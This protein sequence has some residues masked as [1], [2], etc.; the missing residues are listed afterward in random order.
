MMLY[1]MLCLFLVSS[2]LFPT[3]ASEQE[4]NDSISQESRADLYE[5]RSKLRHQPEFVP[6]EWASDVVRELIQR[7]SKNDLQAQEK[8]IEGNYWGFIDKFYANSPWGEW[9]YSSF[10]ESRFDPL[11]WEDIEERSLEDDRYA[12]AVIDAYAWHVRWAPGSKTFPQSFPTLYERIIEDAKRGMPSAEFNFGAMY[13][14]F[15]SFPQFLGLQTPKIE[16]RQQAYI[17]LK[18][19]AIQGHSLTYSLLGLLV[20]DGYLNEQGKGNEVEA[21]RWYLPSRNN[22]ISQVAIKNI[23]SLYV[24]P[25]SQEGNFQEEIEAIQRKIESLQGEHYAQLGLNKAE[26]TLTLREHQFAIPKLGDLYEAITYIEEEAQKVLLSLRKITP[27]FM[28]SG[29]K[30]RRGTVID[31]STEG[32]IRKISLQTQ[33]FYVFTHKVGS[34]NYFTFGENNASIANQFIIYVNEIEK[35]FAKAKKNL[36][37]LHQLYQQELEL[38]FG[39]LLR[40]RVFAVQAQDD[41]SKQNFLKQQKYYEE[42]EGLLKPKISKL[43]E[44]KN[45]LA[46]VEQD[47]KN[48][49]TRGDEKRKFEFLREHPYLKS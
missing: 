1:K 22:K 49:I 23:L 20:E 18:K 44:E 13:L 5:A 9:T 39:K 26:S 12:Y 6:H 24:H 34:Q 41:I 45:L 19:A 35:K 21:L 11:A 7:A 8:L 4:I 31:Q 2:T 38:A 48:L 40:L 16:M 47:I 25:N 17:W 33:P 28:I 32:L 42:I 37:K 36:K 3:L 27:G 30:L 29:L 14:R 10:N 46:E 15:S 43:K